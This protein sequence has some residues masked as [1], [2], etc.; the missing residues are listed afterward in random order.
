[1]WDLI[2]RRKLA[3]ANWMIG[4]VL[5]FCATDRLH[6][7]SQPK[8]YP[9]FLGRQI[10]I[11][12]PKL[13]QD[14]FP[15]NDTPSSICLEGPQ[16][17]QCYSAPKGFSRETA[18][19]VVQLSKDRPAILSSVAS[20]GASG[21]QIA[22]ALLRPGAGKNLD[23]YFPSDLSVS[24]QS[25][26]AFWSDSE[27][28]DGPIFLTADYIWGPGEAHYELH[29]FIISAYI[30]WPST[31]IDDQRR[32]YLEDRYMTVAKYDLEKGARVLDAEKREIL[33][34]LRRLIPKAPPSK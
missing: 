31:Y 23:N 34:R 21:W 13:D 32:Y 20:W 33:A 3:A 11:L 4:A 25:Q 10:T 24:N 22:F 5:L 6:C 1:M 7:Q 12:E 9:K 18:V 30:P 15:P 16:R 17:Q 27:I 14:G 19:E 2:L 29:R 28:S 8:K 26:H